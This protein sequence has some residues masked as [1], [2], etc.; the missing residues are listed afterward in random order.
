MTHDIEADIKYLFYPLDPNVSDFPTDIF[1]F[2][3]SFLKMPNRRQKKKDFHNTVV[4]IFTSARTYT[5]ESISEESTSSVLNSDTSTPRSEIEQKLDFY[6]KKAAVYNMEKST[7]NWMKKY[8]E[9][10]RT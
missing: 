4:P 7:Q 2:D 9:R 1:S 5:P 3:F 10:S 6:R 8:Q